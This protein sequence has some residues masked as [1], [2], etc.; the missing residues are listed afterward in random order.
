MGDVVSI[1]EKKDWFFTFG[2]GQHGGGLRNNYVK[3]YGTYDSARAEMVRR[4]G[5]EWSFQHGSAEDAGVEEFGLKE[6]K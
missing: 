1:E 3:I 4:Y 2:Y 5:E 6:V